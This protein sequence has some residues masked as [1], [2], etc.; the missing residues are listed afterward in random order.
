MSSDNTEKDVIDICRCIIDH[1]IHP[2]FNYVLALELLPSG[3]I[4][5][6]C[7][8]TSKWMP[9]LPIYVSYLTEQD[10]KPESIFLSVKHHFKNPDEVQQIFVNDATRGLP[11]AKMKKAAYRRG[12]C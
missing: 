12:L 11:A 4:R 8:D 5:F 3:A 10:F 9:H 6:S 1:D 2:A 7:I